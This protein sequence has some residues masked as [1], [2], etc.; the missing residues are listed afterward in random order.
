MAV[1]ADHPAV[2]AAAK[3][4]ADQMRHPKSSTSGD[5][6]IDMMTMWAQSQQKENAAEE[7]D[8]FESEL[9]KLIA[10]DVELERWAKWGPCISVD[11]GPDLMLHTALNAAGIPNA[12]ALP[13]KTVMWVNEGKITVRRGYRADEKVVWTADP[14]TPPAA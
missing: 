4:W 3:W 6:M 12:M 10:E 5:D 14:L 9:A 2:K 1:S 13:I 11:Y 7:I 8:R